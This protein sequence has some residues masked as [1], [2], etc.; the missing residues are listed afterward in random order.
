[1]SPEQAVAMWVGELRQYDFQ[2]G[3]FSMET[4]HFTQVVWKST[5]RLGC[6]SASCGA[7]TVWV[8]NYEA[9]GN[10]EGEFQ[11]NVGGGCRG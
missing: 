2:R 4:G 10:V 8:C 1:M 11:R 6:A 5:Q 3:G 9:A 7:T